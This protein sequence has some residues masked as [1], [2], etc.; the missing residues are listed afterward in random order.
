[1]A[2]VS[3][4]AHRALSMGTRA[5]APAWLHRACGYASHRPAGLQVSVAHAQGGGAHVWGRGACTLGTQWQK[6]STLKKQHLPP[7]PQKLRSLDEKKS[8]FYASLIHKGR[9]MQGLFSR[10][11]LLASSPPHPT[12]ATHF[13]SWQ[14]LAIR[15]EIEAVDLVR[16]LA[17]H[18]GHAEAPQHVVRQLHA[19]AAA[20]AAGKGSRRGLRAG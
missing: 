2:H 8:R 19:A 20:A 3:Q 17:E 7:F 4:V 13:P 5:I 18:F 6:A 16:V 9:L 14:S 15:A 12:P 10:E 1:M 11:K